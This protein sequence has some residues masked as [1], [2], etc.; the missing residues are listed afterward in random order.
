MWQPS[1]LKQRL[2][3][4][5]RDEVQRAVSVSIACGLSGRG[6]L[7]Y[8]TAAM[9]PRGLLGGK[10]QALPRLPELAPLSPLPLLFLPSKLLSA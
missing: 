7:V 8:R 3:S 10:L 4:P 2:D 6:W 5:E 1:S 9:L